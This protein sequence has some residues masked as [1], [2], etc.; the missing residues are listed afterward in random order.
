[1]D[2]DIAM[3]KPTQEW[4]AA[5]AKQESMTSFQDKIIH[6]LILSHPQHG[7][8][9]FEKAQ[10]LAKALISQAQS[11]GLKSEYALS[12]YVTV[13][14]EL[15]RFPITIAYYRTLLESAKHPDTKAELML[16]SIV[17]AKGNS[18]D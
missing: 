11:V 12:T 1:M 5:L 17:Y 13:A 7:Q 3:T 15:S 4:V 2:D 8:M 18:D 6:E 16:K 9:E 14:L 10:A